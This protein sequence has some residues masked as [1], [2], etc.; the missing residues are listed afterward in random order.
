M[1]TSFNINLIT[2]F[3]EK[4]EKN[5]PELFFI[6]SILFVSEANLQDPPVSPSVSPLPFLKNLVQTTPPK[7]LDGLS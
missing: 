5:R 7:W 6:E 3:S 1:N 2:F 4:G